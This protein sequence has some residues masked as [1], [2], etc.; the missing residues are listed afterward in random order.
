MGHC[1][2]ASWTDGVTLVMPHL[3]CYDLHRLHR[4]AFQAVGAPERDI[5]VVEKL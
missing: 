3:P 5:C 2:P 4:R 1:F